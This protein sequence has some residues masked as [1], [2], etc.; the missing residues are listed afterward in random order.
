MKKVK[1][2]DTVSATLF[3]GQHVTGKVEGIEI[4]AI[5]SK[6]GR[7]VSSCDMDKHRNGV[8]ELDCGHWCYFNQV[9]HVTT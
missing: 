1:I 6:Y 5:D 7:P 2:G 9:R 4:C 3:G 8:L